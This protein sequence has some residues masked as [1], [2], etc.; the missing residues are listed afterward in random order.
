MKKLIFSLTW[1]FLSALPLSAQRI[2]EA[3]LPVLSGD[4]LKQTI[5]LASIAGT[6][7]LEAEKQQDLTGLTERWFVINDAIQ[8]GKHNMGGEENVNRDGNFGDFWV[9][10]GLWREIKQMVELY[11]EYVSGLDDVKYASEALKDETMDVF[12]NKRYEAAD[13][14]EDMLHVVKD[15]SA[16]H[17]Q[18]SIR[19]CFSRGEAM[20]TRVKDINT[21]LKWQLNKVYQYAQMG[22]GSNL[23]KDVQP[24]TRGDFDPSEYNRQH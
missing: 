11:K 23:S 4:V 22:T 2:D 7:G 5:R 12:V 3:T 1:L 8:E 21:A 19:Q 6:Q 13:V 18:M 17:P 15:Q 20:K 14:F 24:G 9:A 16:A 10:R